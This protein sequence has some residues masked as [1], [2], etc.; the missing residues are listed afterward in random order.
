[1]LASRR[2]RSVF[3]VRRR[4]F[5]IG[6][7]LL[8]TALPLAIGALPAFGQRQVTLQGQ[9]K[10]KTGDPKALARLEFG[11][12]GRYVVVSDGQGRYSIA[13]LQTGD[14]TVTV[15]QGGNFQV[16]RPKIDSDRLDF[17]VGW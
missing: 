6:L 4:A 8:A 1:M 12:P 2:G 9:V 10:G 17:T 16:F 13:Q 7:A 14:Y 5:S 3:G 15:R 11:G